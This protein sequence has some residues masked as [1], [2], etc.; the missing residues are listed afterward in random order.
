[1]LDV[2]GNQ[3]PGTWKGEDFEERE[4]L[5]EQEKTTRLGMES[6]EIRGRLAGRLPPAQHADHQQFNCRDR[7]S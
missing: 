1:M 3:G 6:L 5:G 2:G 4:L 7:I